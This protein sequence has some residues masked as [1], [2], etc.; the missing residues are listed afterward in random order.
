LIVGEILH[1]ATPFLRGDQMNS[2]MNYPWR[3]LCL[4]Y[5]AERTIGTDA[6]VDNLTA[7]QMRYRR[8]VQYAMWNLLGS[9]D[10]PRFLTLCGGDVRR[11]LLASTF[12]YTYLG[13][14]YIY[15][16][17][18]IGMEGDD[19]PDCRRCMSWDKQDW[20]EELLRHYAGLARLR[21]RHSALRRGEFTVLMADRPESPLVY[22]RWNSRGNTRP[23]IVVALN[24]TDKP[25]SIDWE[26]VAARMRQTGVLA[27]WA[28]RPMRTVWTVGAGD[29]SEL[30]PM[31]AR[32]WKV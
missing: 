17:D 2:V 32:V 9:H 10:R 1:D 31:S 6:F 8:Q 26:L 5:F 29:R 22:A 30:A 4:H 14:P 11:V 21:R 28:D 18:E 27:R 3:E 7:L 16:G 13:T 15:Y 24:N 23:C 12:Q 19:D 25:A 20:D